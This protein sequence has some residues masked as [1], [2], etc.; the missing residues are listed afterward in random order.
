MRPAGPMRIMHSMGDPQRLRNVKLKKGT[1]RR[2]LNYTSPY[3][4]MLI[5][6]VAF[7]VA[8]AV[9]TLLPALL[10]RRMIGHAILLHHRHEHNVLAAILLGG[11][12]LGA[13]LSLFERW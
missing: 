2:V 7:I 12:V 13:V 9:L 4:W 8:D 6:F 10:F 11:A 1:A 5:G 3:R